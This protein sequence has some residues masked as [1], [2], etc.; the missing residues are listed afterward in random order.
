MDTSAILR[1]PSS[2]RT[3]VGFLNEFDSVLYLAHGSNDYE[4]SKA[5]P[6]LWRGFVRLT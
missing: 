5:L 4:N 3:S 6:R 1:H 2:L